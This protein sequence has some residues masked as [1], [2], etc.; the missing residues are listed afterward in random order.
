MKK[1]LAKDDS[2]PDAGLGRGNLRSAREAECHDR[3]MGRHLLF[4]SSLRSRV[5]AKGNLFLS[6]YRASQSLY[7]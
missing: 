3:G 6:E 5:A 7:D 1:S 4:R 2:L